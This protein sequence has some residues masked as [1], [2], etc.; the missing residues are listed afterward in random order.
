MGELEMVR[1]SDGQWA[2]LHTAI[3]P[4]YFGRGRR[5]E[6][7]WDRLVTLRVARADVPALDLV[8]EMEALCVHGS[9]HR[10][11]RLAWIVD[12]AMLARRFDDADWLRLRTEA[13]EHG[14]RRMVDVALLL[15]VDLCGADIPATVIEPARRDAVARSLA[16][17]AR[18]GLFSPDLGRGAELRFHLRMWDRGS[19]QLRYLLNIALT[20]SVADWQAISLP[21]RLQPLYLVV[22]PLRMARGAVRSVS[23]HRRARRSLD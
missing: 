17:S 15:A 7:F 12:I 6:S 3:V 2:E 22:R 23:A 10:W 16:A 19:D 13:R 20:P 11:E 18:R 5:A 14:V 1:P 8:D 9:K 4:T 21:S